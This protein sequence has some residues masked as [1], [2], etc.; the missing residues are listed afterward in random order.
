MSAQKTRHPRVVEEANENPTRVAQ[1][2]HEREQATLRFAHHHLAKVRPV[3]LRLFSRHRFKAGKGLGLAARS[4]L[5]HRAT[6][7]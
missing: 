3:H 1:R 6:K 7:M 2:H 4:T 5:R